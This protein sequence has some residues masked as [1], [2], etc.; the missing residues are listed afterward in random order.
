MPTGNENLL[1]ALIQGLIYCWNETI[2]YSQ[3]T[4]ELNPNLDCSSFIWYCL[5]NN[6][7]DVGTSPW[8]TGDMMGRL[9]NAGF[10]EY[11]WQQNLFTPQHGDIFVYHEVDPITQRYRGHTFFYGENVRA[12]KNGYLG[13]RACD[14]QIEVCPQVKIEASGTHEHDEDGDQDNG[15][16]A[17][18]EV[19]VHTFNEIAE[20]GHTWHVFRWGGD[21]PGPIPPEPPFP[22]GHLPF[23]LLKKIRDHNF[24]KEG[25]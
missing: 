7:F 14:S 18:T 12:Y 17:H 6:G 22:P 5:Y 15:H 10:T 20:S 21:P 25:Y 24:T 3:T 13:W 4:R 16:G 23:W 8:Y 9:V 2:G 1:G 11:I 19:W